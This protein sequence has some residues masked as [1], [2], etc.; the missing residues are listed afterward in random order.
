M[1]K[2][3]LLLS[4]VLSLFHAG[5]ALAG[6][7]SVPVTKLRVQAA[8]KA[9]VRVV[10]GLY[11]SEGEGRDVIGTLRNVQRLEGSNGL[12]SVRMKDGKTHWAD[13]LYLS[14]G[15]PGKAHIIGGKHASLNPDTT[16][17]DSLTRKLR[18]AGYSVA[19]K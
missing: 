3:I 2:K 19:I 7:A 14:G 5:V 8:G 12:W 16:S 4:V 15:K 10:R 11:V 9:P 1:S 17:L 18:S 13:A 6:G